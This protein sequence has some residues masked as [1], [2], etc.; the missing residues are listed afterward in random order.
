MTQAISVRIAQAI[1]VRIAEA[2]AEE[3]R[4]HTFTLSPTVRR[5]Y[6]QDRDL[7]LTQVDDLRIDVQA[8]DCKTDRLTQEDTKYTCR[9][10][11]AIRKHFSQAESD[12][13]TGE[14]DTTE[15]DRL[16]LLTEQIHDFFARNTDG[17]SGRRLS[18]YEEAAVVTVEF[19]PLYF[20][21]HLRENR[22]FTGVVAVTHQVIA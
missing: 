9:T 21:E 6:I 22:Q 7:L 3:L 8:G 15:V 10:D 14:I 5:G 19:R 4:N 20:P 17:D 1:S 13:D 18:T 12:A 11:I 2:I 16:I